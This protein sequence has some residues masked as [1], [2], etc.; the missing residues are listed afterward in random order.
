ML[1]ARARARPAPSP[2]SS[3]L[4]G[5]CVA[6]VAEVKRRSP[7]AGHLTTVLDPG[8]RA[9]AYVSGGARAVSVLTE[10]EFFGGSVEDLDAVTDAVRVPVLRKD[11]ILDES[12]IIEARAAGAA[13]VLLIVRALGASSLARL[14]AA[15]R[16]WELEALVEVHDR[17]ELGVALDA[18]ATIVGVNSRDLGTLAIDVDRALALVA[19]VPKDRIAVAESGLATAADVERAAEAGADAVLVGSALSVQRDATAAVATLARVRR[20]GR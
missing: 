4:R 16:D 2:L 11:F 1:E 17:S 12:Q 9:L 7:S 5:E 18:G 14:L 15:A 3:A 19:E 8:E 20:R 13:A 10:P 6:V